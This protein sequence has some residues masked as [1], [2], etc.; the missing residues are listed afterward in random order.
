[1]RFYLAIIVDG[2]AE[3]V[4][5]FPVCGLSPFISCLLLMIND[6]RTYC[7]DVT[8]WRTFGREH[9]SASMNLAHDKCDLHDKVNRFEGWESELSLGGANE[10]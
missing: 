4:V 1:M 5:V 9:A 7:L 6:L 10:L 2:E 3:V 8:S